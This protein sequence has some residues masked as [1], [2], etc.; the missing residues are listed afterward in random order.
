MKSLQP[1]LKS[2]IEDT[3]TP[4][5]VALANAIAS[6]NKR[7]TQEGAGAQL[8][9]S[10]KRPP[11]RPSS[12]SGRGNNGSRGRG[13]SSPSSKSNKARSVAS[14]GGLSGLPGAPPRRTKK[15]KRKIKRSKN[16]GPGSTF[17]SV[18]TSSTSA[19]AAEV[20]SDDESE[21]DQTE[22]EHDLALPSP[23]ELQELHAGQGHQEGQLDELQLSHPSH[24]SPQAGS[25]KNLSGHHRQSLSF[26]KARGALSRK[27]TEQDE[28]DSDFEDELMLL[29]AMPAVAGVSPSYLPVDR[30]A[31]LMPNVD[32]NT[33]TP[34]LTSPAMHRE[35]DHSS[36]HGSSKPS[37]LMPKEQDDVLGQELED[38]HN[39]LG[40]ELRGGPDPADIALLQNFDKDV[41]DLL[42]SMAE[43]ELGSQG[44]E[45]EA[46][47]LMPQIHHTNIAGKLAEVLREDHESLNTSPRAVLQDSGGSRLGAKLESPSGGGSTT[48]PVRLLPAPKTVL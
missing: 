46:S 48:V 16:P 42:R 13:P 17:Q 35:G 6:G 9:M 36:R 29:T 41:N 37:S 27:V 10:P 40:Q 11:S 21:D 39:V 2:T 30:E 43:F 7:K 22:E 1:S 44:D 8:L 31:A 4:R 20:I 23:Y 5:G 15:L 25:G 3:T 18:M 26:V 34:P 14:L 38:E 28:S 24:H 33:S 47:G 45:A 12:K 19:A 32:G